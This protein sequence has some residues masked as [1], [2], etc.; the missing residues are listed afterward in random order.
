MIVIVSKMRN[1]FSSFIKLVVSFFILTVI[2]L[3]SSIDTHAASI[4]VSPTGIQ[5]AF[6]VPGAHIEQE[7]IISRGNPNKDVHARIE[8]DAEQIAD[9]ITIAPT[10]EILL[11]QGQQRIPF[12]III[13]VPNDVGHGRY[14]GY[15]RVITEQESLGQVTIQPAVRLD[16]EFI[17]S[18]EFVEKFE[19][20]N[21]IIEPFR[22]GDPLELQLQVSNL[23]NIEASLHE[24]KI[25]ILDVEEKFIQYFENTDIPPVAPF[26]TE[27]IE[28]Y[29]G[30]V[31]LEPGTYLADVSVF[32]NFEKLLE[33]RLIFQVEKGFKESDETVVVDKLPETGELEE[34]KT[35]FEKIESVLSALWGNLRN[36][37]TDLP[38]GVKLIIGLSLIITAFVIFIILFRRSREED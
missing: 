8:I 7:F 23:G 6:L 28:V 20:R 34:E 21:L 24:V 12:K 27:I 29:F 26:S 22:I 16:L 37:I 14:E 30:G 4:G 33:D 38:T 3:S 17:V 9:W 36:S 5:N 35:L 11:P 19:V 10:T 31:D 15:I 2:W 13:D 25:N 18:G 32:H 1:G